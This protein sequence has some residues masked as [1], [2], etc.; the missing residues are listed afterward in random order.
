[1]STRTITYTVKVDAEGAK[2]GAR[3]MKVTM[4]SMSQDSAKAEAS[5][6]KL[7]KSIGKGFNA[8]VDVAEDKTKSLANSL[9]QGF[10]DSDKAQKNFNSLSREYKLL[11][12]R[13]GRTAD[14]QEQLNAIYRLGSTATLSQKKAT[15]ELV[16]A[17]QLQ[18]TAGT[19]VQKSF[20]GMRGQM[21]N[22]GYQM[23]D[24]AVQMQM[25]T[26][27]MTIFSQ[28][29]S[30]LA[31]G[32]GPKGALIGAGIAFAGMLGSL[33]IP[34]LFKSSAETKKLSEELINLAKTVGLT[35]NQSKLLV[36]TKTE[37]LKLDQKKLKS[38][39]LE[40]KTNE[41]IKKQLE[42]QIKDVSKLDDIT[43]S[44]KG[45]ETEADRAKRNNTIISME[46]EKT[47]DK[48]L[49]QRSEYDTLSGAINKQKKE[50]DLVDYIK[51]PG[52]IWTAP[53]KPV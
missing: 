10:R 51:V 53:Y 18:R 2:K 37:S 6:D 27:A 34:N 38:V 41:K 19:T 43:R 36:K 29:G 32:F 9:K 44:G 20:R 23:Q 45:N 7:G 39:D 16:K 50:I 8:N 42:A 15:L 13:V 46:L 33:L 24:V 26:N 14:Q 11:S 47:T 22:F 21:Q 12:S 40:I 52:S 17:Y 1:M 3:D 5:M 31:A 25:G 48:L 35:E 30:Q 28:Q 49:E 4:R